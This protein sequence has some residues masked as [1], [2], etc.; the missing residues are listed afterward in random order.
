MKPVP[1]PEEISPF[2]RTVADVKK[3]LRK[4]P[5]MQAE[6]FFLNCMLPLLSD[7]REETGELAEALGDIYDEDDGIDVD[8]EGMSFVDAVGSIVGKATLLLE[9]VLVVSNL[10]QKDGSFSPEA[11]KEIVTGYNDLS[12]DVLRLNEQISQIRAAIDTPE[13]PAAE[14]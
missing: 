13:K 4:H 5:Q 1:A 11:P 9:A 2:D 7:M 6:D 14:A 12:A 8:P 10:R 3:R